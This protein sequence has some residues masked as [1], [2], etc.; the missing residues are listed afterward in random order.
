MYPFDAL[1]SQ[2]LKEDYHTTPYASVRREPASALYEAVMVTSF[3]RPETNEP[4]LEGHVS[5]RRAAAAART[6]GAVGQCEVYKVGRICYTA[7]ERRLHTKIPIP[8]LF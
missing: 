7:R 1:H 8:T 2:P 4:I 3:L 5:K 6:D